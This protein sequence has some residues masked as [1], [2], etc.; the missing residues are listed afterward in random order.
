MLS[1]EKVMHTPA[2]LKP[3]Q[4]GVIL[5]EVL[6]SIL[7]FSVGVLA[8]VGLQANMIQNTAEAKYR[9][10]ASYIAQVRIGRMWADPLNLAAWVQSDVDVPE[11]PRGKITVT[12]PTPGEFKVTVG[13]TS[14]AETPA[15]NNTDAPCFMQVAHCFTTT[16][17]IAGG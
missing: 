11:L 16:A 3:A 9:S 6:V 4:H 14:P 12:Q 5:I 10:E 7:I 1:Q 15:P 17:R 8:I 2:A 13:W